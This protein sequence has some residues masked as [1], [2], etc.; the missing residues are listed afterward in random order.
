MFDRFLNL[1]TKYCTMVMEYFH[2]VLLKIN[3]YFQQREQRERKLI[4]VLVLLLSLIVIYNIFIGIFAISSYL[5]RESNKA[6]IR[7]TYIARVSHSLRDD[8]L[9]SDKAFNTVS[10]QGLEQMIN[11]FIGKMAENQSVNN[12]NVVFTLHSVEFS[13]VLLLLNNLKSQYG[14]LVVN[15]N[16]TKVSSGIVNI[17]CSL[18]R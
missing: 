10:I 12:G 9:L 14:L 6:M 4:L 16:I 8:S 17:T 2:S 3:T 15:T 13:K 1:C 18:H 7:A 11:L 5:H